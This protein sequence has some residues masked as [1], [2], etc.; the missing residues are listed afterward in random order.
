VPAGIL[1]PHAARRTPD[2]RGC[3]IGP[4]MRPLSAFGPCAPQRQ[5]TGGAGF[6]PVLV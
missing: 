6:G 3:G 5:G 2:R 4:G 1:T